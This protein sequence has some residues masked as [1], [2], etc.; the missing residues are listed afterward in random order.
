[1]TILYSYEYF[2]LFFL[3]ICMSIFYCNHLNRLLL[4]I[5][6]KQS[7]NHHLNLDLDNVISDNSVIIFS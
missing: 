3:E 5:G 1:M 6:T 2:K 7:K 4:L